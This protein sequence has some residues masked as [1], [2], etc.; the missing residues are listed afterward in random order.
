[1]RERVKKRIPW[2]SFHKNSNLRIDIGFAWAK[3]FIAH[4]KEWLILKYF[5][6]TLMGIR[7][8]NYWFWLIG[9]LVTVNCFMLEYIGIR[10]RT[11]T[12]C[13]PTWGIGIML[14]GALFKVLPNWRHLC[15]AAA[16]VGLPT[17]IFLLW[18]KSSYPWFRFLDFVQ[19]LQ[20][21]VW[22]CERVYISKES[23]L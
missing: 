3:Y 14:F 18:V 5:L 8:L 19:N 1:M 12:T 22:V 2:N 17:S 6:K 21:I 11:I 23:G 15:I 9:V 4:W 7:F 10:W 20:T 13:F 16:V